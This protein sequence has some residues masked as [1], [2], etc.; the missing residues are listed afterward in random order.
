MN[1]KRAF[2]RAGLWASLIG[3][4]VLGAPALMALMKPGPADPR[5]FT[6]LMLTPVFLLM[7]FAFGGFIGAVRRWHRM[8]LC[9]PA[10]ER[11]TNSRDGRA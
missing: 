1:P 4:I 5:L 3:L 7:V 9:G 2:V 8:P 10:S 6:N 11:D